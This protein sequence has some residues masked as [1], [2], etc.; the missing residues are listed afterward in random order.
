[1][2]DACGD[3]HKR[4]QDRSE[5]EQGG[6]PGDHAS[7]FGPKNPNP[8]SYYVRQEVLKQQADLLS[9]ELNKAIKSLTSVKRITGQKSTVDVINQ[10][11]GQIKKLANDAVA[12]ASE[13]LVPWIFD[14]YTKLG[15]SPNSR[16]R[17]NYRSIRRVGMRY[18][19][20]LSN[21]MSSSHD[22]EHRASY[23]LPRQRGSSAKTY[24]PTF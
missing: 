24:T 2:D 3:R 14:Y 21:A 8:S 23:S 19:P 12:T 9:K 5:A 10:T 4:V 20:T 16:S 15:F 7:G 11:L 18:A 22:H 17:E 13:E 6:I 1:M